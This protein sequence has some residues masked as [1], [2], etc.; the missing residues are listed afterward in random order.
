MTTTA[1]PAATTRATIDFAKLTICHNFGMCILENGSVDERGNAKG[2]CTGGGEQSRLLWATSNHPFETGV[3]REWPLYG[4]TPRE[5]SP[6]C[7][8]VDVCTCG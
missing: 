8:Y 2:I 5:T 3:E 4:R 1:T 6:G 7:W